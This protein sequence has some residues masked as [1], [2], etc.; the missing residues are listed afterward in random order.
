MATP[1]THAIPEPTGSSTST[2]QRKKKSSS[3]SKKKSTKK[4]GK[5]SSSK[6][7]NYSTSRK[8][9]K[10]KSRSYKSS[11]RKRRTPRVSRTI[12]SSEDGREWIRKGSQG[13]IISRD[14]NGIVRA[15]APCT[16]PPTA[17]RKYA[18]AINVYANELKDDEVRVYSLIAP[19][20][21]A[22]Y[23]PERVGQAK[24]VEQ[25]CIETS[26]KYFK[27]V[28][29]VFVDPIFKKHV[30]EQ[31]Y[32]RTDHHWG[33]LGGY[34]AA[35]ALAKAAKVGFRPLSEYD[36][37]V[38]HNYVGT[39]YKFSGDAAVKTSP[40][41]FIYYVPKQKGY[42]AEFIS[43][44]VSDGRTRSQKGP[45]IS[46][47]FK[48]YPD[49]SAAAYLTFMGG[50]Y[51]NVKVTNT[52]T[53]NGRRVLIVK[54]SFGNAVA[55]NLFGSFEEVH[56]IDFRYFPNNLVEYVRENFITDLVFINCLSIACAPGTARRLEHMYDTD[57]RYNIEGYDWKSL[58]DGAQFKSN[59]EEDED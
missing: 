3:K 33:P 11:S 44:S 9:K 54:D 8:N 32:N 42:V 19:S 7:R 4:S 51:C 12:Y 25:K 22:Y 13:I 10:K 45:Y 47:F 29:P 16:L 18:E 39:M 34:Y 55:S 27:G 15:M 58:E 24:D 20:Q 2:S 14:T 5:K 57:N 36:E 52:G 35:Q 38:I 26:S 48:E 30:N 50:D 6:K 40:E 41:K 49:G 53:K 46:D 43:Y 37:K 17:G 31:I 59:D 23:M 28:T 21:G 56:V 1:E